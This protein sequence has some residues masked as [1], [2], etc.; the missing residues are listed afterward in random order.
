MPKKTANT[1]Q[2]EKL[3]VPARDAVTAWEPDN[4][5]SPYEFG[6][7][8]AVSEWPR[9]WTL[10]D[11]EILG[12]SL[13]AL[14]CSSQCPGDLILQTYDLA[15]A[16]RDAGVPVIGGFHSPMEEE[17]LD[18]LLRG[19]QPIV[20]CPARSIERM[21]VPAAWKAPIDQGRLLVL[22]PFPAQHCRPTVPLAERRNRLVAEIARQVFVAHAAPKSKTDAFCRQL[23]EAGRSLWTFE[24]PAGEPLQGLGAG[25]FSSAQAVVNAL[26]GSARGG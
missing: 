15:R 24:S 11:R 25:R 26:D 6:R 18:L 5:G 16:L 21:R 12:R 13:L 17:C 7:D 2:D 1:G 8:V 3:T 23:L 14:F 10:G 20:V 4:K 22:S 9:L 19:K